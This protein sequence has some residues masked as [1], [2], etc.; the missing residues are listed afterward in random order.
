MKAW[1]WMAVAVSAFAAGS[2]RAAQEGT[3]KPCVVDE[4]L[5]ADPQTPEDFLKLVER[6]EAK[7]S[8]YREEATRH[9]RMIEE[10]RQRTAEVRGRENPAVVQ[11]R[12]H[13]KEYIDRAEKLAAAA[14]RL[15]DYYRLRADELKRD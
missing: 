8:A 3:S 9:R 14:D 11:M 5:V 2:V 13:C 6:Y 4:Q 15:A 1:I 10:T 7:A 12:A